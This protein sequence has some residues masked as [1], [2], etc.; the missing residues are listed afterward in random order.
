MDKHKV[1]YEIQLTGSKIFDVVM[2]NTA[3]KLCEDHP[4]INLRYVDEKHIQI[5][6]ELNDYWYD[7]FMEALD[8]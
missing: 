2:Y 8:E 6:G 3:K 4:G 1:Q 5:Y 7:K